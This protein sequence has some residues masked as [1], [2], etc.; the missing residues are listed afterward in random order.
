MHGGDPESQEAENDRVP[1]GEGDSI[2][3][4]IGEGRHE[5]PG[6]TEDGV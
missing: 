4:D 5:D 3:Y 2:V 1:H 6:D